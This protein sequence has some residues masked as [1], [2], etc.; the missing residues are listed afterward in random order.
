VRITVFD[1]GNQENELPTGFAADV[2][3]ITYHFFPIFVKLFLQW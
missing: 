2:E 1:D 3:G